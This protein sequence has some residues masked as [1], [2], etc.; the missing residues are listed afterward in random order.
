MI[1]LITEEVEIDLYECLKY[2]PFRHYGQI[3]AYVRPPYNQTVHLP[4]TKTRQQIG[5]RL[6]FLAPCCQRRT[7]K[8]YAASGVV[9]CRDCLGL[10]YASQYKKKADFRL[11]MNR[12][13][14][15]RLEKQK[16]RLWYA[17]KLTQ[18]GRQFYSLREEREKLEEQASTE[19]RITL[20]KLGMF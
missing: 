20:A 14:L 15:A 13:K 8:L 3:R 12:L 6:W 11:D 5:N 9:A 4:L 7:S 1:T 18:F 10:K 19:L 16:R 17:D 2:D